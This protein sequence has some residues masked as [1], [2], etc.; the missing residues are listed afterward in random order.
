MAQSPK[1]QKNPCV[2]NDFLIT[3]HFVQELNER[4]I[5]VNIIADEASK[6]H[7]TVYTLQHSS[8]S[9]NMPILQHLGFCIES[10]SAFEFDHDGLMI[11]CRKYY[12]ECIDTEVYKSARTNLEAVIER[13]LKGE[14]GNSELNALAYLGNLTPRQIE[15]LRTLQAYEDQL[16]SLFSEHM[17]SN[18]LVKHHALAVDFV[19]YFEVK[20]TPEQSNRQK[21]LKALEEAIGEK[22]KM[23]QSITE[24]R[25]LRI[26]FRIIQNSV[27]TNYYLNRQTIALKVDV[28]GLADELHGIQPRIEAFIHHNDFVGCHLRRSLVSR[29]GLRWSDRADDYRNEVKALMTAQRAKNAVIVPSG[30]KG[31]FYIRKQNPSK[32]EFEAVYKHFINALLDLVDNRID[33]TIVRSDRVVAYD[34]DDSYFV[35]AADKGTAAMSDVANAIA[36]ERGFWLDDAF[37]SG[38]SKGYNHKEMGITA[39]GAI[40]STERFFIEQGVNFYEE[41]ITVIGIGSPSGDVFGNGINLSKKFKLLAAIGSREIFIDPDPNPEVAWAERQRLFEAKQGWRHYNESLISQGGGVFNKSAKTIT[42]T[43]EMKKCFGIKKESIDGES[44]T[45]LLLTTKVD[46]LFNGGVGTYVKASDENNSEIGDKPNESVRVNA[47]E[48]KAYAVSE[49][50]N[51]GF[52]QR[53]RIEY[54]MHGGRISMDSIDNSAGVQTSDTEVNLKIILNELMQKGTIKDED[55][56]ELLMSMEEDVERTMIWTNYFQ[57]LAVSLDEM[58]SKEDIEPFRQLITTLETGVDSFDRSEYSIPLGEELEIACVRNGGLNRPVL[59]IVHSYAKLYVKAFLLKNPKFLESDYAIK[60]LYGYF[61]KTFSTIYKNEIQHHPLRNEIIAT[62]ISNEVINAQG[63]SFIADAPSL[64]EEAFLLKIK[65]FLWIND[66]YSASD[67]RYEIYREDYALSV[68]KQYELLLSLESSIRFSVD[69]IVEH[70]EHA[71]GLK[72]RLLEYRAALANFI[73]NIDPKKIKNIAGENDRLNRFFSMIDYVQLSLTIISV[74]ESTHHEFEDVANLFLRITTLFDIFYVTDRVKSLHPE[75]LW[76]E[77][78]SVEME[79]EI[80]DTIFR[81][82]RKIMNFK[83]ESETIEEA[84]DVFIE[85]HKVIYERYMEDLGRYKKDTNAAYSALGVVINALKKVIYAKN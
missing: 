82:I 35:V 77:R 19:H 80:Y 17:I 60:S 22:I 41:S 62:A 69:W 12:V 16:V 76:E 11:Y 21:Q 56:V 50:G 2:S 75:N 72:E 84:A 5:I 74:Q 66:L 85:T 32:E 52:T 70:G 24:D 27:R 47:K 20:F 64:G 33:G 53:A 55:R 54:A 38:G 48:I 4:R 31:G 18:V 43:P 15:L 42:V 10:E 39:K 57:S 78:L 58:R 25:V 79:K 65:A 28:L 1:E 63:S 26:L 30:A 73:I 67:I 8:L 51:L 71:I 36:H 9:E 29:G 37:A 34:G 61:P 44:L 40:K 59:S 83:R 81:I 3:D 46:M 14:M 6:S 49:G 13:T 23:I 68:K 7:I 45:R